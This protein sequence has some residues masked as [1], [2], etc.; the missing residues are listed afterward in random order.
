LETKPWRRH[1]DYNV[2]TTVRVLRL[3]IHELIQIPGN[4]YPDKAALC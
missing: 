1:F 2:P 4:A 3:P